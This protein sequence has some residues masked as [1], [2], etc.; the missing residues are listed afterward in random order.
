MYTRE[1]YNISASILIHHDHTNIVSPASHSGNVQCSPLLAYSATMTIPE[2]STPAAPPPEVTRTLEAPH[3][4]TSFDRS[5]KF[6]F[7]SSQAIDDE[8]LPVI[9][10]VFRDRVFA[11][12]S[13]PGFDSSTTAMA[14][15]TTDMAP[16]NP[17]DDDQHGQ[18]WVPSSEDT[19]YYRRHRTGLR[20]PSNYPKR[21]LQASTPSSSE[22]EGDSLP[23]HLC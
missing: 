23:H 5:A 4:K 1:A 19:S 16:S 17:E 12:P 9:L 3:S 15:S 18:K 10:E 13:S 2:A 11:P 6:C 14:R 20:A 8:T 22:G 21:P 7:C